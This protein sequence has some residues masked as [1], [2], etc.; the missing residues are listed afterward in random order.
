MSTKLSSS[1]ERY[2]RTYFM[3]D[4]LVRS[5]IFESFSR[6]ESDDGSACDG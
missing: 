4:V 5:G 1:V 2:D 6:N 3:V